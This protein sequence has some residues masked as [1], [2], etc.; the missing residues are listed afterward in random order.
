VKSASISSETRALIV[1]QLALSLADAWRR[2]QEIRSV[3]DESPAAGKQLGLENARE[4]A[5]SHDGNTPE[6]T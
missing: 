1:R 2:Q 4:E 5:R 3:H 6:N